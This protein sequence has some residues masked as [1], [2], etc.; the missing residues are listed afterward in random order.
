MYLQTKI[1]K[2][3]RFNRLVVIVE[4]SFKDV[5]CLCDCGNIK[6]TARRYLTGGKLFSCGCLQRDIV[7]THGAC[8][9]RLY[10]IWN[11]MK[12]RCYRPKSNS[13]KNYGARGIEVCEE[14]ISNFE[15]FKKW[16]LENGYN[17]KLTIDKIDNYKNYSPDNC[18]WATKHTQDRNKRNNYNITFRGETKCLKD[19]CLH[20][21]MPQNT[22][23]NRLERAKMSIENA[24]TTPILRRKIK[25]AYD[26]K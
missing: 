25:I 11:K 18:R 12:D 26:I 13:Y 20:L 17:D 14:W 6:H 3:Q 5:E 22:L 19:W 7:T 16:A 24:F 1:Y 10:S 8:Y 15:A 9:T 23:R 21:N 4:H 2:G